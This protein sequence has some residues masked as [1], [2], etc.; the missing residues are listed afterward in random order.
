MRDF[1][2][3]TVW[4]QSHKLVLAMYKLTK[5]FP[6]DEKFGIISQLRRAS[7]SIPTNFAEGCGKNSEKEF[8]R[9]L[10]IAYGSTSE[11][12][13]LMLLSKDLD[14]I[15]PNDYESTKT[16]IVSIQKQLYVLIQKLNG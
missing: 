12:D 16:E 13:Y 4:Q 2:T 10:S 8:A 11:V 6:S 7:T 3:Y 9:Y 15:S 14:Y 5:D 1:R